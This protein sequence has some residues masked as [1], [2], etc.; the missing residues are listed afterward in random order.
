MA[1][2]VN[3]PP[4][5][6]MPVSGTG[7][8]IQAGISLALASH[9][10]KPKLG[11]GASGGAMIATQGVLNGWNAAKWEAQLM[12]ITDVSSLRK[13]FLGELQA[14]MEP[15][16]YLR[17][18]GLEKVYDLISCGPPSVYKNNET[19]YNAY[20]TTT[21]V[22]DLF[23]TASSTTSFLANKS[24]PLTL[25]GVSPAVHFLGDL[26]DCEY[27]QRLRQ[28]LVATSAVPVI[29]D[30]APYGPCGPEQN[31]YAD[32]GLNFS[33]PLNVVTSMCD[34]KD[35]IYINPSDMNDPV[36]VEYGNVMSNAISYA[37][38]MSRSSSL[39]DRYLY[40]YGLCCGNFSLINTVTGIYHEKTPQPFF[41][42]VTRT[43]GKPRM[44]ELYPTKSDYSSMTVN[45]SYQHYMTEIQSAKT[46]FGYRIFYV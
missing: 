8:G 22:T 23:T 32:G 5:V 15:S 30:R 18:S 26:P 11:L 39:K 24:G 12:G 3:L 19:I 41:D 9:G 10:Y 25:L 17:G 44:I 46:S 1:T 27:N 14:L 28:V 35:V 31:F 20:N 13:H 33:S 7:L 21:G 36:P 43:V 34:V 42:D 16:I 37:S 45:Q 38:Q 6:V 2:S 4:I 40:I 29:Y